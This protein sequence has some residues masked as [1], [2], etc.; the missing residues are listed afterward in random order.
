M[1]YLH[2]RIAKFLATTAGAAI[3]GFAPSMASARPHFDLG[4]AIDP[5]PAPVVVDHVDRVWVEPVYRTVTER[6][7]IDPVVENRDV[8]T[9]VPDRYEEQDVVVREH[10]RHYVVREN[11]LVEPGHEVIDHQQVVITP[12]HWEDVQRQEVVVPG[13]YED[14]VQRDVVEERPEPRVEFFS[15][16]GRWR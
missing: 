5:A 14:R 12:G 3:F 9:W 6:V 2:S 4:I 11:V 7:W 15:G 13:H 10:H 16:W 8:R 1:F